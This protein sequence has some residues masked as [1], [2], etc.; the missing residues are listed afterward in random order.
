MH[1]A[2]KLFSYYTIDRELNIETERVVRVE[3]EMEEILQ[4]S[5]SGQLSIVLAYVQHRVDG[6]GRVEDQDDKVER[7]GRDGELAIATRHAI[8]VGDD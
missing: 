8:H 3:Q 2:Q 4:K 1:H 6:R 5:N 7:D